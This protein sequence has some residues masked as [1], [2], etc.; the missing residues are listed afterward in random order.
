LP[1][2]TSIV[3]A[4]LLEK[5]VPFI[6]TLVSRGANVKA[7]DPEGRQLIH[8]AAASGNAD[9]IKLVLTKGGDPN[10]MTDPPPPPVKP[11]PPAPAPAA[12]GGGGAAPRKRALEAAEY[13]LPPPPSPTPP[14][15]IAAR[16]GSIDGMKAL[17]AA[18][19][20]PDAKAQD[21]L[22]LALAAA[23]SGNLEALK[24]ALTLDPNI[25]ALAQGGKSIMH[26]ALANRA[27][28]PDDTEAIV[29][30]L[31]DKGAPLAIKDEHN[32]APGD[33]INRVGPEE[34]RVFYKKLLVDRGVKP[35]TTH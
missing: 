23:G 12:G 1:D 11:E 8:I 2:G 21:G 35:S 26:M 4:A 13:L 16:A 25:N 3:A 33:Y 34:V 7:R 27:A 22:T 19:A 5:D 30:Y 10:A 20:K 29:T 31:A 24:F 6:E 17:L 18:G 15:L 28:P 9:L 14:L 32:I